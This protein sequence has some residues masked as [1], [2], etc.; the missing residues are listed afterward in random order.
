M[1]KKNRNR[2]EEIVQAAR[3]LLLGE[4]ESRFSVR[5][6]AQKVGIGAS[7]LRYYFPAQE[8]LLRAVADDL[9][10]EH[11]AQLIGDCDIANTSRPAIERFVECL[12]QYVPKDGDF[13]LAMDQWMKV[14]IAASKQEEERARVA[15]EATM[16]FNHQTIKRW[17]EILQR[18][19]S[20]PAALEQWDAD[21]AA[22][23]VTVLLNG[24]LM[25]L[26]LGD[27][28]SIEAAHQLLRRGVEGML[29]S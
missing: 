5:G 8:D 15:L 2:K 14:Q 1:A 20:G 3:E 21:D 27:Y 22:R 29:N 26:S 24:L 18:P 11:S 19:D 17:V 4:G 10:A 16:D 13:K 7:T 9:I 28:L 6:V 23:F 25:S 12:E